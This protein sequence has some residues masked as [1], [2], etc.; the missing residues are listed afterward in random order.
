MAMKKI[1]LFASLAAMSVSTGAMAL[2]EGVPRAVAVAGA[3]AGVV[4]FFFD[5]NGGGP[6]GSCSYYMDW[7]GP[8]PA[9]GSVGCEMTEEKALGQVSCLGS[10]RFDVPTT[11]KSSRV[12]Q[13]F[14]QYGQ[15]E[16]VSLVLAEN[17]AGG[18]INGLAVYS[19]FP[20][21]PR[22]IVLL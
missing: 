3:P 10:R 22:S 7:Q 8:N 5:G 20:F 13:G 1:M 18:P 4:S 12:C 19:L 21:L 6:F 17:L 2:T 9:V 15:I 14:D 16:D 11:L